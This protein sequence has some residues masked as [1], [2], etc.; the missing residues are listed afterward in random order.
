MPESRNS[1]KK[2]DIHLELINELR[3]RYMTLTD[4]RDFLFVNILNLALF[5][6]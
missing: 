6:Y 3:K 2:S 1:Y 4:I 5:F